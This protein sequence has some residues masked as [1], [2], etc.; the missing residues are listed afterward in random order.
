MGPH[1][2][3]CAQIGRGCSTVEIQKQLVGLVLHLFLDKWA[4]NNLKIETKT[5]V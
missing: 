5:I 3:L 1:M 4:M 2:Y